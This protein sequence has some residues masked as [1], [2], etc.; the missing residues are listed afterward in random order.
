MSSINLQESLLEFTQ[1][2]DRIKSEQDLALS[3]DSGLSSPYPPILPQSYP[4]P[5]P[6]AYPD[7][8]S[9]GQVKSEPLDFLDVRSPPSSSG[10]GQGQA[11]ASNMLLK[12][13][14]QDRSFE[15][16]YN[17]K[18]CDFGVTTGYVSEHS[19]AT[20]TRSDQKKDDSDI[21]IEPVLDLAVEQVKKDV[22]STCEMLGISSGK[23]LLIPSITR[24]L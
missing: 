24:H 4:S 21:K 19:K 7:S 17:L 20:E 16:K 8:S 3:L 2:Q 5:Q 13:C 10:S 12:Q 22:E 15:T 1:L 14:L 23:P 6:P 9:T 18:P 11:Q